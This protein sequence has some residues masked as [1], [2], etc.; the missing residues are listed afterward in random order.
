MEQLD[1]AD[2]ERHLVAPPWLVAGSTGPAASQELP[3]SE[4]G[5]RPDLHL[6]TISST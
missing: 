3:P 4:V 5:A 6:A 2:H 1:A